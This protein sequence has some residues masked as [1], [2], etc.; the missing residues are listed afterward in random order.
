MKLLHNCF[1]SWMTA[2]ENAVKNKE[3]RRKHTLGKEKNQGG[4]KE[5][6][7]IKFIAPRTAYTFI[8]KC[9]W[10][11]SRNNPGNMDQNTRFPLFRW[12]TAVFTI[13]FWTK[14][15]LL[16]LIENIFLP[17]HL[18]HFTN[19]MKIFCVSLLV[20]FFLCNHYKIT[21]EVFQLQ[22]LKD[23][24]FIIQ[25]SEGGRTGEVEA[26]GQD[27]S[28]GTEGN[29]SFPLGAGWLS[30]TSHIVHQ[31]FIQKAMW[32]E[33]KV[34]TKSQAHLLDFLPSTGYFPI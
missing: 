27:N 32:L 19:R 18:Q 9:D 28:G 31:L 12:I 7:Q 1:W 10:L 33:H 4:Y 34:M 26:T 24:K 8:I 5:D 25:Q 14:K 13:T 21:P 6:S 22:F 30:N 16:L 23:W 29:L 2:M 11:S 17:P 15:T 20:T 3:H